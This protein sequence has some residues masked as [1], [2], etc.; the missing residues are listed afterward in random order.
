MGDGVRT[1]PTCAGKKADGSQC[2][3]IIGTS[4]SYCYAHNP[5]NSAARS[6]NASRAAKSKLS[7]EVVAIRAEIREIMDGIRN[8]K[9]SRGDGSILLQGCG[10]LLK[11]VNEGRRQAEFDEVRN[12]M[13]ELRELFKQTREA[14]G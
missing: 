9:L 12:E 4:S 13:G 5:A 7:G 1:L 14:D 3:R 6:K 8:T 2:E 10:M 11:A